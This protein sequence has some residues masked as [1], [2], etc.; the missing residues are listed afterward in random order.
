M[1]G[2]GQHSGIAT[3]PKSWGGGAIPQTPMSPPYPIFQITTFDTPPIFRATKQPKAPTLARYL[4]KDA[5]VH[6]VVLASTH[7]ISLKQCT[8]RHMP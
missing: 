4:C 1:L 6:R 2:Y 7:L 3:L 8:V 5:T